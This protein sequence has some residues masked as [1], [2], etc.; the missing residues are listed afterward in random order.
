MKVIIIS[1]DSSK[2]SGS[3]VTN[4]F[5]KSLYLINPNVQIEEICFDESL[6]QHKVSNRN[7]WKSEQGDPLRSQIGEYMQRL[8]LELLSEDTFVVWHVDG[9]RSFGD[10]PGENEDKFFPFINKYKTVT[11]PRDGRAVSIDISKIFLM[12]PYY[13]IESWLFPFVSK[14]P[15]SLGLDHSSVAELSGISP[16]EFDEIEKI[17]HKF[18][19]YDSYNRELSEKVTCEDL[20]DVD[21]SFTRFWDSL[22]ESGK[23]NKSI[24]RHLPSWAV[25]L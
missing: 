4:L 18:S 22:C 24:A 5:K 20:Y 11:S 10:R 1:E 6:N 21:K 23:L 13:S 17:K 14:L 16:E 3:I 15:S 12:M 2:H 7:V 19:I 25:N 8:T 9:D